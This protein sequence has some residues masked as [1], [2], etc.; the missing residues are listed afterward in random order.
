MS[1][2]HTPLPAAERDAVLKDIAGRL[3]VKP[4]PRRRRIWIAF[5][6]VG[7]A[8]FGWLLFTQPQRAWGAWAINCVYWL[9]IAQGAV[10]LACAIRLANG[11]WG[12]PVMRVAEA[13]S[14]YLPWGT[15]ALVVLMLAGIGTYLPWVQHVEPRQ[16]PY[17]NVPFLMIRTLVGQLLLWWLTRDLVRLS[18]RTDAHLLKNHVA[19]ELKPDY[20]KLSEGWRGDQVEADW[21]RHRLSQRAPMIVIAYAVFYTLLAWDFIMSITPQWVSTLFGWWF[22]MGAFLSGIAMTA[23]LT[24]RLRS[25]YQLH[26]YITP[27]HLWDT[28]KILFGFSVFWVYQFWSQYLPIWYANMP[29]ETGF[30]FLRFEAPWRTLAFTVFTF[31][32]LLPFLGLMNMYTKKSPFWLALFSIIVL[33][34]MWME[35]SILIM[36]SLSPEH[37]WVGL[38]EIGVSLGFLGVFG[39]RVHNFVSKYPLVKVP[40][41]LAGHGGHH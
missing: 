40:D 39:W 36:P 1:H 11:R 33:F 9:G 14:A 31:V 19:A 37:V 7:I 20:E 10:V 28:G 13:L 8:T 3:P 26:R 30:V 25:R 2:G 16:A 6:V 23:L 12:G 4:N 29:E 18:L 38:P 21:Q 15:G 32:F 5:M 35:R 22:I 34:G 41:V 27:A 17:L 24:S